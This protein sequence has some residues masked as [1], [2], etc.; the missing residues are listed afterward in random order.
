MAVIMLSGPE[1]VV[2]SLRQWKHKN[3]SVSVISRFV[4]EEFVF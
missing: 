2:A 3:L 1:M 4:F